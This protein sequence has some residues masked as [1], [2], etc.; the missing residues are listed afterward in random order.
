V[1]ISLKLI[2][3]LACSFSLLTAAEQVPASIDVV[4]D[5]AP[6]VSSTSSSTEKTVA[7]AAPVTQKEPSAMVAQEPPAQI[8]GAP[9]PT[10]NT[11]SQK[12]MV[13]QPKP[14]PIVIRVPARQTNRQPIVIEN[15]APSRTDV[16]ALRNY[17]P[18]ELNL[19]VSASI[20]SAMFLNSDFDMPDFSGLFWNAGAVVIFPLND[21]TVG[22]TAGVL[23]RSRTASAVLDGSY[24]NDRYRFSQM[25]IDLP[26]F[27]K[28]KGARSRLA[29][30]TGVQMSINFYDKL[31]VASGTTSAEDE[32]DLMKASYRAPI[33]WSL[34]G[35]FSVLINHRVSFNMK[36]L[37][38]I[39]EMYN[40]PQVQSIS[41][42]FTPVEA[43]MGVVV[44]IL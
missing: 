12:R 2:L 32:Y 20:G 26:L 17:Y 25:S 36:F 19:A 13:V 27:F 43:S 3:G 38:G 42:D 28:F 31:E 15:D 7:P 5:A 41:S 29:F 24:N 16:K 4:D 30:D 11:S 1:N 10:Q 40:T 33:D 21:A 23:F 37:F 34:V 22:M 9:A 8:S 39:S 14:E 44:N 35:G 18:I 6:A